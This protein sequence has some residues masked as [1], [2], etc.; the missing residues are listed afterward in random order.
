MRIKRVFNTSYH[1]KLCG[2][3]IKSCKIYAV[4]DNLEALAL[5]ICELCI[6]EMYHS[7]IPDIIFKK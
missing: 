5:C 7:K 2:Y 4:Y 3:T 1:C 6:N